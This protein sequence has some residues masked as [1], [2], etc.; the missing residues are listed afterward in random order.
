MRARA[1]GAAHGLRPRWMSDSTISWAWSGIWTPRTHAARAPASRVLPRRCY[2]PALLNHLAAPA[3][4]LARPDRDPDRRSGG[5]HRPGARPLAR[6]TGCRHRRARGAGGR[7][8]SGAGAPLSRPA[9]SRGR[10]PTSDGTRTCSANVAD[11]AGAADLESAAPPAPALGA[12]GDAAFARTENADSCCVGRLLPSCVAITA[13]TIAAATAAPAPGRANEQPWEPS[14]APHRRDAAELA[15]ETALE[16]R[17]HVGRQRLDAQL[18]QG[19]AA[20]FDLVRGRLVDVVSGHL[21]IAWTSAAGSGFPIIH[22]LPLPSSGAS[23][24]RAPAR[25]RR[26]RGRRGTWRCPRGSRG[27]RPPLPASD[28]GCRR[29][30]RPRGTPALRASQRVLDGDTARVL[31]SAV[32]RLCGLR[33][34]VSSVVARRRAI[35]SWLLF[36][37]MR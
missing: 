12:R 27:S 7:R 3:R 37:A 34:S 19:G 25:A 2:E 5:H 14:P 23:P 15:L 1:P 10:G 13:T 4:L 36:T 20:A 8:P 32:D 30:R 16:A 6:D 22:H 18:V 24:P 11:G 21:V 9:R 29:G 35:T 31:L 28:R 33:G 26:A 17:E